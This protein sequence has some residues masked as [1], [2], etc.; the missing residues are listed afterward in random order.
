MNNLELKKIIDPLLDTFLKA[1]KLAKE[2]RDLSNK[3]IELIKLHMSKYI[4]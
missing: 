4:L 3:S 1:G 2:S